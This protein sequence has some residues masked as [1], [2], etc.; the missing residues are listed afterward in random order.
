MKKLSVLLLVLVLLLQ[1]FESSAAAP[2]SVVASP[3]L[4]DD[5][6]LTVWTYTGN[7]VNASAARA[8]LR[9]YHRSR[10][11]NDEAT[12]TFSGE[13]FELLYTRASSF[14]TLDIYVDNV[15]EAS[16]SQANPTVQFQ[17]RWVSPTYA[18]GNHD[19]RLVHVSGR[20]VS[21]DGI[22]IFGPPDLVP[23]ASISDLG[24]ATGPMGGS[25]SLTWS[26][27]GDDGAAGTATGY[28]VRYALAP[29]LNETDWDNALPAIPNVPVPQSAGSS[30][31]MIVG[32]LAPGHTYYFAVRA[33]DEE[34]NPGGLSNSPSAAAGD[35]IPL[36][37]GKHDDRNADLHYNGAWVN[38]TPFGAYARTQRYSTSVGNAVVFSFIGTDFELS[39]QAS[40][41]M[42]EL[43][44]YI[45]DIIIGVV[46][47]FKSTNQWQKK[48]NSPVLPAGLHTV[49]LIHNGGTRVNLDAVEVKLTVPWP[50]VSL[51]PVVSGLDQPVL[52][53]HAADGSNRLFIVEKDGRILIHESGVLNPTPFL[54][55]SA[56]VSSGGERG[57]LSLAFPPGYADNHFYVFY[58]DNSGD[59][60]LSRFGLTGSPEVAD[61]T[62][63]QIVLVIPHPTYGNH[64]GGHIAFGPDGYLY[65]STGDGGGGGDPNGNGQNINS[66]LG[67]L[68]RL[69]V[70]TGSPATYTVPAGNPF[71]GVAGADEIWAYGMRNPWR[72]SFDRSTGD[73]YIGDVGQGAWEEVDFQAAGFAGGANY[74]WNVLEGNH[75]YS[76]SSG[77]VN[78]P[79]YVPPVS[80][81]YHGSNDSYGCSI[82]GGYMYR[83]SAHPAMQGVY[84]HGDY[85][86]GR[87]FGLQNVSGA[88]VFQ[89]LLDTS[90]NIASFGEDEAGNLYLVDLSGAIYQIVAP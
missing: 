76:P 28:L 89:Q 88:W 5:K 19:V 16:L 32:G 63:E 74:G 67:K 50:A 25:A 42:G 85:C 14:G 30:E 33:R 81:Y 62:S 64:N 2:L 31:S 68:L 45:D 86:T 72:W 40:S 80:E 44:I 36:S 77:C 12:L 54:D 49:Q 1:P 23:P 61:P 35:S 71:V 73:I 24:A 84:F 82:T 29:I 41:M 53:T 17:Q 43:S 34:P 8:Y 90:Y 9:S 52:V 6:D 27:P 21:V 55:I 51:T 37:V 7:W 58:T 65:F 75:C 20:L 60:T 87:L 57:L 66:L 26:A 22:E 69:D 10:T 11:L 46:D 79:A 47:Q 15:L 78:P 3:A 18:D 13:R 56:Q 4:Y 70:E 59:L 38:Q 83:G 39:Y 48:W